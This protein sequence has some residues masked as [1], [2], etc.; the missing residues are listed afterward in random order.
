M[1]RVPRSMANSP[2]AA[3]VAPSEGVKLMYEQPKSSAAI[4]YRLLAGIAGGLARESCLS[5][6]RQR[7]GS[8]AA[9]EGGSV[10]ARFTTIVCS[11]RFDSAKDLISV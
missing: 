9:S 6:S 10:D 7:P 5:S 1:C 8:A 2:I 4:A 11:S 3:G